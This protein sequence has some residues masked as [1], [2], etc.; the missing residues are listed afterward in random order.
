MG[1][2]SVGRIVWMLVKNVKRK[3]ASVKNVKI[4]H[5]IVS[6]KISKNVEHKN[7]SRGSIIFFVLFF[8]VVKIM[9]NH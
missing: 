9:Q 4:L 8:G 7:V 3:L 5:N 1:D 2:L 6:V